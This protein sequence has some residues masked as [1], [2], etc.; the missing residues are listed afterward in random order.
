MAGRDIKPGQ[1]WR[2]EIRRALKDAYSIVVCLS[3]EL[4]ER[5]T[6]GMYPELADAISAYREYGPN[7]IFL[8]PIRF[9]EC[10]V[11]AI[12]ID[13]VGQLSDLQ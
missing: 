8:I 4:A 3:E 9:S 10:D 2:T 13:E 6:S 11:P 1:N 7:S 12:A 5:S